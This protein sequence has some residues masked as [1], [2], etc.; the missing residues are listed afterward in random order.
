MPACLQRSIPVIRNEL[1]PGENGANHFPLYSDAAAMNNPQCFEAEPVGFEEI[2]FNDGFH[3]ARR[4]GVQIENVFD[5]D[6]DGDFGIGHIKQN[7]A[8]PGE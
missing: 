5:G 1:G 7:P 2:F 8:S 4:D 3:I 6:S